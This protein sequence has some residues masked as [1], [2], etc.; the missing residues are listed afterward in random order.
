[1][2][3]EN[4][5]FCTKC[6]NEASTSCLL[7]KQL[8]QKFQPSE[9][10]HLP[11]R[12]RYQCKVCFKLGFTADI[13]I[14]CYFCKSTNIKLVWNSS[15]WLF[16]L[17]ICGPYPRPLKWKESGCGQEIK[18]KGFDKNCQFK[19]MERNEAENQK[20]FEEKYIERKLQSVIGKII[21]EIDTTDE[22]RERL[23]IMARNHQINK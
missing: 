9:I 21:A 16:D 22:G 1:M 13:N 8:I 4:Y 3:R 17:N 14:K 7:H 15:G 6:C 18:L 12:R 20:S 11:I 10:K 23:R 5:Y 19:K 2:S